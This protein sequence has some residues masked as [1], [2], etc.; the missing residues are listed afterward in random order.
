MDISVA[1]LALFTYVGKIL[2]DMAGSTRHVL[3]HS[4]QRIARL[5]IVAE[6]RHSLD[7]VPA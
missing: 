2:V 3:M 7:R 6:F 1:I 4:T 5:S